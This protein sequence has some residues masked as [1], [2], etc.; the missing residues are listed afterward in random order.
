MENKDIVIKIARTYIGT[1][2][3]HQGRS[4][5]FGVDCVGLL[6]CTFTEAGFDVIDE[7]G[8]ARNPDGK[9]LKEMLDKQK[10]L[11][12]VPLNDLQSGDIALF[13]VRRLPQHVALMCNGKRGELN[14]IH[15]YNGGNRKVVEHNF[16]EFW[17]TRILAAYRIK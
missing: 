15:A 12:K 5:D 8:Y 7:V 6:T 2:W 11:K 17:K 9:K 4:K 10:A 13:K 1:K 16:A 14:M 3:V